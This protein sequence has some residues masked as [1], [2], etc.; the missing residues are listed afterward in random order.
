MPRKPV[1]LA[2][3]YRDA[4]K[5]FELALQLGCSPAQARDTLRRE[6]GERRWRESGERLRAAMNRPLTRK[7]EPDS[8]VKPAHTTPAA[9]RRWWLD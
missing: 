6:E 3:R 7:P 5:S 1:S 4:R 8:V 9:P 2:D